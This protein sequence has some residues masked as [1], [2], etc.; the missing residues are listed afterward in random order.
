MKKF[1]SLAI[2]FILLMSIFCISYAEDVA[3]VPDEDVITIGDEDAKKDNQVYINNYDDYL[4]VVNNDDSEDEMPTEDELNSQLKA[5][6]DEYQAYLKE[7]YDNYE[8]QVPERA[9]IIEAGEVKEDYSI[10]YAD[11]SISKY[12]I[13]KV[14]IKI[15]PGEKHSG[16]ELDLTYILTADSMNN[17]ILSRLEK[18]DEVFVTVTENEDGTLQG[19]ISNSWSTV[20]RVNKLLIIGI[21]LALLLIIYGS[22]KGFSTALVCVIALVF[23]T[24]II[25]NFAHNGDGVIA[26]GILEI[27]CLV[28]T[29]TVIQLGLTR[30]SF[31]AMGISICMTLFAWLLIFFFNYITRTVGVTF[32]FAAIAENVI[33]RNINFEHLYYI[34]T[35][36]VASAFITNT[37]AMAVKKIER[38][39]SQNYDERIMAAREVLPA[40]IIP[41]MVASFALYIP[42]HILLLTNK[43]GEEEI[44]NSETLVSEI[45]R[46]LVIGLCITLV[47]PIVSMNIFGFGKKYLQEPK[48]EI[49][50]EK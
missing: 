48:Q 35:L 39:C 49:K 36:I 7:Y 34:I 9:K 2:I 20:K 1:S 28:F 18:G 47:I 33:L 25:P 15:L 12:V 6:Y 19:N 29:I 44:I 13:Q 38:E 10:S 32:E 46:A 40:N 42:N 21:I 24:I 23:A 16:D 45:I 3:N 37:V 26:V 50:E 17:I 11:Q 22:K 5:Y 8:R 14:K 43:F 41:F 30:K 27:L 4:D 31:K